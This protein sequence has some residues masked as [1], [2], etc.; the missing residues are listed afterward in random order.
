[1]SETIKRTQ[2]AYRCPHCGTATV[3]FLGGLSAV[4]DMLRLRCGCGESSLDITNKKDGKLQLTVP[5][6]YCKDN[7]AFVL[8]SDIILRNEKTML[9]CPYSGMDIA[10]VGD[11]E[12]ISIE[13][14]RS[15]NELSRIMQSLEAEELRDIQPQD[16]DA[17]DAP[18]DPGMFDSINF[19]VR[20]LESDGLVKCPCGKE[21]HELRFTDV[22]MQVYCPDCGASYDFYCKTVASAEEYLTFNEIILK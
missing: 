14:E 6:V 7:H 20:D 10:F 16:V 21:R 19:L 2:I 1:M 11:E 12:S 15:A 13:L 22:G 17:E 3:G 8:Q 4:S 18:P 5:C 9:S